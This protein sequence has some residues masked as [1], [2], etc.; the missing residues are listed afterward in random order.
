MLCWGLD[1]LVD[2]PLY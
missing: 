1:H 2:I